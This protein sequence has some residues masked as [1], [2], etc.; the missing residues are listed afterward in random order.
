[1]GQQSLGKQCLGE[2]PK[3]FTVVNHQNLRLRREAKDP[4]GHFSA[5]VQIS[6]DE[7][8]I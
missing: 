8:Q 7:I 3:G 1:M 2:R 6:E 4:F 5:K